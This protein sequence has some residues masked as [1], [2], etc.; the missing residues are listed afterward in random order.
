[1]N[2]AVITLII[3]ALPYLIP[4]GEDIAKM[5]GSWI[6]NAGQDPAAEELATVRAALASVQQE[7]ELLDSEVAEITAAARAR[8][9]QTN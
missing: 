9:A 3:A 8:L 4:L 5:I 1:M 7:Q 6:A 2:P